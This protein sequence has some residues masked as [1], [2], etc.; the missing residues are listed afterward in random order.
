[1]KV[2]IKKTNKSLD[3]EK[4]SAIKQF[5][6]FLQNKL[7]LVDDVNFVF[8]DKRDNGMTTGV[9]LPKH[10]I[11]I[12]SKGRLLIDILRTI[13]H[14]WIH[15]YQHQKMG[16]KDTDKIQDIGGP[17]ENM[18]NVLS[19]IFIK[20]FQE[21]YPELEKVNYNESVNEEMLTEISPKSVGIDEF[22]KYMKN[23]PDDMVSLGFKDYD[24]LE[25][26]V[27]TGDYEEFSELQSE[28]EELHNKRSEYINDEMDEI[29]RAVQDLSRDGNL[30]TTVQDVISAFVKAKK[31]DLTKD[32]WSKLENTESNEIKKGE[33]KKVIALALK[34]NKTSPLKLKKSLIDGD[35]NP[36]IILKFGDRYHLVAGN[37]RLSTAAALGMTPKVL[38]GEI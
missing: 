33:I 16:V 19:G 13:S 3:K 8:V 38:I 4:I 6:K 20:Q 10:T 7:S 9:R 5:F 21:E 31:V 24:W 23:N 18:S 27:L 32:I 12:L 14:E 26:Y 30:E 25:D 34:Y 22:L 37:T 15:E 11:H 36:P 17:E 2:C 29:E 1:M 28:L 35:Y